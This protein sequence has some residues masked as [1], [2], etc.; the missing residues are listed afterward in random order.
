MRGQSVEEVITAPGQFHGY[1][2]DN[3]VD[4]EILEAVE[5]VFCAWAY[6]E[7][8]MILPPYATTSNYQ[9]F[10]GDGV[11]NWFREEY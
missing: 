7:P 3:P 2:E 8:A 4:P 5:E 6:N 9:Y 10:S 1:H 11:H